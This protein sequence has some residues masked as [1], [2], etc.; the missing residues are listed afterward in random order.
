MKKSRSLARGF[1]VPARYCRARCRGRSGARPGFRIGRRR[2]RGVPIF[3]EIPAVPGRPAAS[4]T[5]E[6]TQARPGAL[7]MTL[8]LLSAVTRFLHRV[9]AREADGLTD[10]ELLDR[11]T[12]RR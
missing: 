2:G 8:A 6:R 9:D 11:F 4:N 3:S 1:R 7:T 10:Q 12:R 5:P